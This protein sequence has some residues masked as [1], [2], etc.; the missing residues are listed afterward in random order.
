MIN[1]VSESTRKAQ[2]KY[3]SLGRNLIKYLLNENGQK[4]YDRDDRDKLNTKY[5][6]NL[7]INS[8]K[9]SRQGRE[10]QEEVA[11]GRGRMGNWSL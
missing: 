6:A 1:N 8:D 11:E 2:K 4:V 5:Y 3:L 7:Y 9:E 10:T